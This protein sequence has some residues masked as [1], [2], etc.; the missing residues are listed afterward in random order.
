MTIFFS[1]DHVFILRGFTIDELE[2]VYVLVNVKGKCREQGKEQEQ[3]NNIG[4]HFDKVFRAVKGKNLS[5]G[6]GILA[7]KEGSI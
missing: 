3:G 4:I 5:L 2:N 7:G 1:W 6:Q